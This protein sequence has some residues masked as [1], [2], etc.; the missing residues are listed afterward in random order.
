MRIPKKKK[1][2][3][4]FE[5]FVSITINILYR[6]KVK[7]MVHFII[8]EQETRKCSRSEYGAAIVSNNCSACKTST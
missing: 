4:E 8:F 3:I 1:Y 6:E 7:I 2:S 5:C